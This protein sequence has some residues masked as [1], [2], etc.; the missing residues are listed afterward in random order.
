[1]NIALRTSKKERTGADWTFIKGWCATN[2]VPAN[3]LMNRVI[4]SL[5]HELR[6][7]K[8]DDIHPI[9]NLNV[10]L[11]AQQEPNWKL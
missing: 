5:A 1:M 10:K 2:C 6:G 11:P 9:L 8:Y 7:M 3:R 4:K